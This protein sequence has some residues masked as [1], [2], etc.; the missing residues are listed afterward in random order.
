MEVSKKEQQNMQTDEYGYQIE[1]QINSKL[2]IQLLDQ[3]Y[4]F[5]DHDLLGFIRIKRII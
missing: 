2:R 4:N 5:M 3:I 1:T